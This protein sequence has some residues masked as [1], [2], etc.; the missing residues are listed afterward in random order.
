MNHSRLQS[1]IEPVFIHP[2]FTDCVHV[3]FAYKSQ[4]LRSNSRLLFFFSS[5]PAKATTSD[6]HFTPSSPDFIRPL[7]HTHSGI[8]QS[9]PQLSALSMPTGIATPTPPRITS[10]SLRCTLPPGMATNH[11]PELTLSLCDTASG[12]SDEN[13][14]KSLVYLSLGR[15]FSKNHSRNDT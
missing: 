6:N 7:A 8:T 11:R 9:N 15:I 10:P 1:T 13:V 4:L 3:L 12:C 2:K 14:H 5:R